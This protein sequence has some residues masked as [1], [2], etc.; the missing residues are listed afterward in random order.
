MSTTSF[1]EISKDALRL[2]S[3]RN[4]YVIEGGAL[5]FKTVAQLNKVPA[6]NSVQTLCQ[7]ARE[8]FVL[9]CFY[10]L[11]FKLKDVLLG[12]SQEKSPQS[13]YGKP[14]RLWL[15]ARNDFHPSQ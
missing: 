9:D 1:D 4:F 12:F 11:T 14:S 15:S 5:L 13:R 3:A 2:C 6:Q 8:E 10:A 7:T